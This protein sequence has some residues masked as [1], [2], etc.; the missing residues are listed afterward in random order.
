MARRVE[1]VPLEEARRLGRELGIPEAQASR[2]AFR[3]L[4]N[5]PDLVKHVYGL[6]TMLSSR[7]KLPTRLRELII[8]RLAWRAGSEYAWFQHYRIST[9]AGV[10]PEEVVAVRDWRKS[11]L[12]GSAERAVLAAA[13]D[14]CEQ[15]KISDAVWKECAQAL[16]ETAVLVEMVVAI[17]NWTMFAQL[18]Q[19][20]E[21][22]IEAGATPWPPDGKAPT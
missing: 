8:M 21:V 16:K 5:H 19:S 18:L 22:E 1:Y 20:L 9:Q 17:G 4:A 2:S 15:G 13:D 14:T 10:T 7:N 12:F 11:D 6:L 3:M